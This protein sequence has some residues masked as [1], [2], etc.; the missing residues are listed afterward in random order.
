MRKEVIG[1]AHLDREQRELLRSANY[2]G[3][4]HAVDVAA[5]IF[6]IN[7]HNNSRWLGNYTGAEN[8]W[9]FARCVE[10]VVFGKIKCSLHVG[11]FSTMGVTVSFATYPITASVSIGTA[12]IRKF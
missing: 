1:R 6:A 5:V 10:K 3:M 2:F 12:A 7:R 9:T 8:R 4:A 11:G